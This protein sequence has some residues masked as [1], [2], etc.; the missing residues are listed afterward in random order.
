[1]PRPNV[2]LLAA[3]HVHRMIA[4][5]FAGRP[6]VIA[7]SPAHQIALDLSGDP[8]GLAWCR[9]PGGFVVHRFDSER[10]VSHYVPVLAAETVRHA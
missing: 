6:L 3:G 8:G 5:E 10:F 7:P 1:M 2:R 9:E 4:T